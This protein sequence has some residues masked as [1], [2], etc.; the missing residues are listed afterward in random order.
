MDNVLLL[1]AESKGLV[2]ETYSAT[3]AVEFA[4][5]ILAL[6]L[7]GFLV[8]ILYGK[9]LGEPTAAYLPTAMST[10]AF[11]VSLAIWFQLLGEEASHRR[12]LV[13][14][15]DW[16]K[17]GG[18]EARWELLID[19]LTAVMLLVVTGVGSLIH[20]Y[21]I[22]YMHG[23]ERF[24]HF[25]AYLN[26][27]MLSMLMLVM[28]SSLLTL[29]VGW[30]GVGLS[31]YLLIGFWFEKREYATAA[32]KA[33][34]TNRVGDVSFMIAMF[35]AVGTF[36]TLDFFRADGTG[37]AQVAPEVLAI[38][39]GTALALGLLLL[40]GA[41]A[42]S[43]QIPLYVWLPD[44]MA[45]P[46]PVS[47]LIHAAT[48]VTAG[49]YLVA[50]TSP[51]FVQNIDAMAV[52]AWIGVATALLAALIAI[53]QDDI[54][55]ILAYS[56]VSQL[57]YMFVGVGAGGYTEGIFHLVTHAFFKGLLFLAAGS[58]M[59]ALA[60]EA[61]VWK[62]GGLRKVMPITFWTSAVAWLAISGVPPF[63][64][65][66]S[67]DQVLV[68]A[69]EHGFRAIWAIGVLVAVLTAF[70]MSRWFFLIFLGES[71]VESHQHPHESPLTMTLPLMLLAVAS[72]FGG[73]LINLNHFEGPLA[74]WLGG[75]VAPVQE[76]MIVHGPLG[77]GAL[78]AISIV[79]AVVG[80]TLAY[81]VY[82][83][84]PARERITGPVAEV[85]ANKF[86]VD[87][88]YEA[89]FVKLGG[90]M[91][92][93]MTWFDAN[94]VDG[95][96]NGSATVTSAVAGRVRRTQTGLVRSYVAGIAMGAVALVVVFLA[97]VR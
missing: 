84:G 87:E 7:V 76:E 11:V 63:A 89:I 86:Y 65:F 67:K 50:R 22:G 62:M 79:A 17:V 37:I 12:V 41:A 97:Q 77:E 26:L 1:A 88:L 56:T 16:I 51:I 82:L 46:T 93:F 44:A 27:F 39:G 69:Y 31:S 95:L 94:V 10:G 30:E 25:F 60:N 45:G 40:G 90:R 71:R 13:P 32:K 72:A 49:V 24:S 85:M 92:D 55:K 48:M 53:K 74:R 6:P 43:A 42:K 54:K 61:N 91:A 57:G 47:A 9:R 52:V 80:I 19:P 75:Y 81:L 20:L 34:I 5:L 35:L 15:F 68:I 8:T 4:W 3:G 58:V 29:F 33:F 18:F 2:T 28:G 66:W 70:Y 73:M 23:D 64:G 59:H 36:G 38:G 83:R 96:V 14:L 21:S 78:I